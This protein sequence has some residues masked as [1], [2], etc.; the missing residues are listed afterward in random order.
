M[1]AHAVHGVITGARMFLHMH[2]VITVCCMV[3]HVHFIVVT[4]G[5][6]VMHI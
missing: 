4:H 6:V 5:R 2:A 1:I 3:M